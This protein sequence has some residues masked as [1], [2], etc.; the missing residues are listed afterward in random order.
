MHGCSLPPGAEP[1]PQVCSVGG[2]VGLPDSTFGAAIHTL[3]P[4]TGEATLSNL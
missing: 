1:L 4:N 3:H 2:G